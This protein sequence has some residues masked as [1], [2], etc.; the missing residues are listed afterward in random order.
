M[1]RG[2]RQFIRG[3]WL[4]EMAKV[5]SPEGTLEIASILVQTRPERI[6]EAAAAIE[7][8]A[9]A[10]IF[11]VDPRG[12]LVVVLEADGGAPIGETLTQIALLPGVITANLVYHATDP[13]Q[14]APG[15]TLS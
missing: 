4:A 8:I 7:A 14:P 2:R 9:G 6:A 1:I 12:K 11:Q 15:E 5:P 10:E 3:Q 13:A